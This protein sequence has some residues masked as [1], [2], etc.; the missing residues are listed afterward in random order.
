MSPRPQRCIATTT[1]PCSRAAAPHLDGRAQGDADGKVHLIFEGH[2]DRGDV[3]ARIARNRQ[4][5]EPQ[6]RLPQPALV[7][8]L[9][10]R[11]RQEPGTGSAGLSGGSVSRNCASGWNDVLA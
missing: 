6:K 5:Y 11:A 7:A 8:H 1:T 9:L 2:E 3:L 4:D 10:Q